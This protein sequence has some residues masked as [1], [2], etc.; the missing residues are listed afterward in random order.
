MNTRALGLGA[1]TLSIDGDA[2]IFTPRLAED[3][4][5]FG[6]EQRLDQFVT[7]D[8]RPTVHTSRPWL[9]PFNSG[10]LLK[11]INVGPCLECHQDMRDP[12]MKNWKKDAPPPPCR[13]SPFR[14]WPRRII[15]D[16]TH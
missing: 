4:E 16:T 10:E 11:I 3:K 13:F 7:T 15:L 2:W 12:V 5:V 1:G 6:H 8:G 9:R 14:H